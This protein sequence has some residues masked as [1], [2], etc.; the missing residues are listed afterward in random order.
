MRTGP[1]AS[2]WRKFDRG[3]EHREALEA[4][5]TGLAQPTGDRIP[6]DVDLQWNG[7]T[8]FKGKF[9][10]KGI[11]L[12]RLTE[13][14]PQL[15]AS[16][17]LILGDAIQ[18]YRAA[19]DHLTWALVKRFN[20]RLSTRAARD[21]QF[22]MHNTARLF[23]QEK[24]RRTPGV[25]DRPHRA[26]MKRYQPYRRG[27]RAQGMRWIRTLSI[28]DKHRVVPVAFL[29]PD[30]INC[31]YTVGPGLWLTGSEILIDRPIPL[32][33]KTPISRL[34]LLA[35]PEARQRAVYVEG[36]LSLR[37]V[38]RGRADALGAVN[39]IST[40]VKEVLTAFDPLV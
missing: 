14:V 33:A 35:R 18:N 17:P 11:A 13:D 16:F 39:L 34:D 38:I 24:A 9:M 20:H 5:V 19:L 29:A 23:D 15:G 25:P 32:N 7:H 36:T 31:T 10:D 3:E 22:P 6:V 2:A 37:P 30:D 40:V 26:I 12:V 21:V 4:E 1:L 8:V 28:T 27:H